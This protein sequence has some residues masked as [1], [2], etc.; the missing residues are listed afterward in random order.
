M[1]KRKIPFDMPIS[2]GISNASMPL[3]KSSIATP[4]IPGAIKGNVTVRNAFIGP[5]PEVMAASSSALSMLFR[6]E[7]M[8]KNASGVKLMDSAQIM[9]ATE[10]PLN[11]DLP[12][13]I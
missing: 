2:K 9:P 7:A 13:P 11:T 8:S 6:V 3:I 12:R 4:A 10:Y 1:L 5:A